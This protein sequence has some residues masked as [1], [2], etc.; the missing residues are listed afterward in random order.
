MSKP[1]RVQSNETGRA[2]GRD[3]IRSGPRLALARAFAFG[4][5]AV[6]LQQAW[7]QAG[8]NPPAAPITPAPSTVVYRCPDN[9]YTDNAREARERKCVAVTEANVT[10]IAAVKAP[11]ARPAASAAN[12]A[13]SAANNPRVDP[14]QQRA[15]D[16]DRRRILDDELKAAETK[17]AELRKEFNNGE[18]ERRG[19]ETRNYQRYLDRVNQMRADI[20]RT[21]ADIAALKR[22]IANLKD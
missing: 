12:G 21:E 16:S 14:A 5:V 9:Y 18:P 22:E 15:R 19:D 13:A 20:G 1:S 3:R 17:L 2:A 6:G 11:P 8:N 4:A 7:A 10:V